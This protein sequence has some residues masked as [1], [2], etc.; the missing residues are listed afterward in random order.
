MR[1]VVQ[2]VRHASV[3]IEGVHPQE[4][5]QGLAILVGIKRGDTREVA[6]SL[7]DRIL[8]LR[9]FPNQT[10]NLD[11]SVLEIQGELLVV[12]QVTLYG[13]CEQGRRPDL[14]EAAPPP[15]ARVVYE[16]FVQA[17]AQSGLTVKTGHFG[18]MMLVTIKNDGPVTFLLEQ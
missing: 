17:L 12:S 16:A 15:E 2:R 14:T 13:N 9:I 11:R 3:R 8:N 1:V 18:A 6:R 5:G 10:Q 7:A 4:I